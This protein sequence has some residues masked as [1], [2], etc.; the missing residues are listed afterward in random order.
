MRQLVYYVCY[1]RYQNFN[2]LVVNGNFAML[3]CSKILCPRMFEN[4]Y[5]AM[6]QW[7]EFLETALFL[8]KEECFILKTIINKSWKL[9]VT[10]CDLNQRWECLQKTVQTRPFPELPKFILA[11]KVSEKFWI[12]KKDQISEV[13]RRQGRTINKSVFTQTI[14][15][16]TW[17]KV[18][19]SS[20][21]EKEQKTLI[22]AS[23]HF[24]TAFTKALFLE[25][26]LGTRLYLHPVLTFS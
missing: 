6:E 20:K 16:K 25:G 23:K 5:F 9:S 1:D 12:Y 7:F 15:E 21:I 22:T 4:F 18:K 24:L 10:F 8:L 26:R 14:M 17:N 19:K 11:L 2:L 3:K 13:W